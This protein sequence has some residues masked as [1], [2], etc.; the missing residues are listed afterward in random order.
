MFYYRYRKKKKKKEKKKSKPTNLFE[1]Y[2]CTQQA[3]VC[4]W[5]MIFDALD[6]SSNMVICLANLGS[7]TVE[8]S[9]NS[10]SQRQKFWFSNGIHPF[11]HHLYRLVFSVLVFRKDVMKQSVLILLCT[12]T[13]CEIW[14]FY[15]SLRGSKCCKVAFSSLFLWWY[16]QEAES[17]ALSAEQYPLG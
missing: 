16:L 1:L 3:I 4:G 7:R 9:K 10:R 13:S 12:L 2:I 15:T 8:N 6:I 17:S 11:F 14:V 5:M